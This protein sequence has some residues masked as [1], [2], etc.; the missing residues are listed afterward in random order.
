MEA[1]NFDNE[2]IEWATL[3]YETCSN[4]HE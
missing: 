2:K 3:I 1:L 4:N